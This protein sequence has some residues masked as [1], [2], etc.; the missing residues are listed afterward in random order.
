VPS[1]APVSFQARASS[2]SV[3]F[4]SDLQFVSGFW[5]VMLAELGSSEVSIFSTHPA[6]GV[7]VADEFSSR[8][9]F[10]GIDPLPFFLL[11]KCRLGGLGGWLASPAPTMC[12]GRFCAAILSNSVRLCYSL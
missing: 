7:L 2:A 5:V 9:S 6:V 11:K 1:P 4:F 10:A 12:L 3:F 8:R